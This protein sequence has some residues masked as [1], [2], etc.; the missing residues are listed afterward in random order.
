[1]SRLRIVVDS[2]A[3][4]HTPQ[5]VERYQLTV[6]PQRVTLGSEQ[7]WDY[8]ELSPASLFQK[9]S[10]L[11]GVSPS[12]SAPSTER[13]ADIYQRL[14][15]E[16]HKVISL[17]PSRALSASYDNAKAAAD[18]LLGRYDIAVLDTQTTSAGL[19]LLAE[20]AGQIAETI[21]SL[22]DAV[23][24]LRGA[25]ARTYSVF[26]VDTLDT[27]QRHA[28]LGEAQ[29]ILGTMLGIKPFITIE[30]GQLMTMEKVRNRAQAVD[31]LVEFVSEFGSIDKLVILK[32][33]PFTSD[34]IR[35]LQDRLNTEIGQQSYPVILYGSMLAHYLG[36]DATGIVILE[37]E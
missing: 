7:F 2:A 21:T 1:M 14:C 3:D 34:T 9:W 32:N 5:L 10:A 16:N 33:S 26:F 15:A 23:R 20:V 27:I 35:L 18:Q 31:K 36:P 25:I 28:L 17:H 37:S 4:F 11:D 29:A 24:V 8:E 22:E 13:F 6:V 19:S 12:I 30:E